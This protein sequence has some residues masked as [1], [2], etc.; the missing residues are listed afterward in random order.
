MPEMEDLLKD[1]RVQV[2]YADQC[3]FGFTAKLRTGS[4]ER[5]PAEKPTG[6]I[7]ISWTDALRFGRTCKHD[8]EHVKLEGGRTKAAALYPNKLS[9]EICKG[10]K[11]QIKYHAEGVKC[12]GDLSKK[13]TEDFIRDIVETAKDF[14]DENIAD[15]TMG[16]HGDSPHHD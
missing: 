5:G 4:D 16:S 15:E 1:L 7:S 12:L 8:H 3:Q 11:E 6:F 14:I 10:F 13:E 2:A 9:M